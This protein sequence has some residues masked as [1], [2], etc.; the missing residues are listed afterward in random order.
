MALTEAEELELLS[1]ER[2]RSAG[3]GFASKA[4][5]AL[6]V[7]EQKSR[8][9][10]NMIANAIPSKEPGSQV[11]SAGYYDPSDPE[12]GKMITPP[13]MYDALVN[14]PKIAAET[15]AEVA[16]SFINRTAIL[17]GGAGAGARL[18]G[19]VPGMSKVTGAIGSAGKWLG[20]QGEAQSGLANKTPGAL[21]ATVEDPL[22][23]L[24]P[25]RTA[26]QKAYDASKNAGN[27]IRDEF[28]KIPKSDDLVLKT[29]DEIDKG[30][31]ST[32][33]ALVA[34]RALDDTKRSWSA[35]FFRYA[36]EKLDT[37]A[38]Q[39]FAGADAAHQRAVMSESLRSLASLNKNGT[40][41][42]L[43]N[44]ISVLKPALAPVYMPAAQAAIASGVGVVGKAGAA[45]TRSPMSSAAVSG[46]ADQISKLFHGGRSK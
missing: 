36:R 37:I 25:G 5:D 40:P 9:G 18:L 42:I 4:W 44:I 29:L 1:L 3:A 34:R 32:Q 31:V 8:E 6:A 39:D 28:R 24:R 14:A 35:E 23:P 43:R 46:L 7:P 22:L 19:K 21:A 30:G 20:E 41:S 38:K 11:K 12:Y 27:A 17:A 16:P 13:P 26:S 45:A 33:E 2:Q 10:L 15:L